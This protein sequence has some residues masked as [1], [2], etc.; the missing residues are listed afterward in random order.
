MKSIK[1]KYGL[2]VILAIALFA[3]EKEEPLEVCCPNSQGFDE[4]QFYASVD[5]NGVPTRL[6][7][8]TLEQH[9]DWILL[10]ENDTLMIR[11]NLGDGDSLGFRPIK[12]NLSE[13]KLHNVKYGSLGE[14]RLLISEINHEKKLLSFFFDAKLG[15]TED[16]QWYNPLDTLVLTAGTF[17]NIPW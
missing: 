15:M 3:C 17:E 14:G 16:A 11:L 12:S 6:G 13:A 9:Q 7:N 2:L 1:I 4:S 10:V 8:V 5:V